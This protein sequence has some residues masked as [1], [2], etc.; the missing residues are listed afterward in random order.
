VKANL[1]R[2]RKYLQQRNG[3]TLSELMVVIIII[4]L[5]S[6]VTAPPLFRY[7]QSNRL[8]TSTDRMVADLQYARSLAISNGQILRFSA[9]EAGYTLTDPT[10]GRLLRE[11]NFDHGMALDAAVSVD[12]FPWGTANAAN[13]EISN[14]SGMNQIAILPTGVVEV[15]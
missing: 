10:D 3:F 12:F 11:K 1:A 4:G 2:F 13:L 15:Q 6:A 8:Q 9:T 7:M 14:K 5:M